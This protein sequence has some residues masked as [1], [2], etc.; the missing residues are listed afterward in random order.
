M[1]KHEKCTKCST[2]LTTENYKKDRIVCNFCYNTN[3]LNLMKK[4]FGLLEENSSTNQVRRDVSNK[5]VRSRKQKC[6][7]N[8]DISCNYIIDVDPNLLCDKLRDILSKLDMTDSDYTMA[9]MILDELL[10]TKSIPKK[11]YNAMCKQLGLA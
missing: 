9:K 8:Q 4:R 5:R 2:L 11:Q 10:R 3:T 7:T 6:S 1:K